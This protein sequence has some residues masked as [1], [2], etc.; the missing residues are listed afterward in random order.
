MVRTDLCSK[1]LNSCIQRQLACFCPKLMDLSPNCETRLC[2]RDQQLQNKKRK[3]KIGGNRSISVDSYQQQLFLFHFILVIKTVVVDV[4]DLR[5]CVGAWE[6][7]SRTLLFTIGA[8]TRPWMENVTRRGL[9][10][11][12]PLCRGCCRCREFPPPPMNS[13]DADAAP[14]LW[15]DC[16]FEGATYNSA[17]PHKGRFSLWHKTLARTFYF[18]QAKFILQNQS[19]SP[20]TQ[21]Q[22]NFWCCLGLAEKSSSLRPT[23][24]LERLKNTAC[25]WMQACW[26]VEVCCCFW[27]KMQK[28]GGR[29]EWKYLS[30]AN[31][32][33]WW[34]CLP[35]DEMTSENVGLCLLFLSLTGHGGGGRGMSRWEP[36]QRSGWGLECLAL[37]THSSLFNLR[38]DTGQLF[39][40]KKSTRMSRTRVACRIGEVTKV[41]LR[42]KGFFLQMCSHLFSLAVN[43]TRGQF[44]CF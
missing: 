3:I 42:P 28:W 35:E 20:S 1:T 41:L 26:G 24:W 13:I 10:P 39:W 9:W 4:H 8:Q 15:S 36:N 38:S 18:C 44:S 34:T 23:R 43:E 31:S 29:K 33:V 21:Q 5:V 12:Q 17:A 2:V 30:R 11:C 40:R 7:V 22:Q 32:V 6:K 27:E 25:V 19:I 37:Q 16:D 14:L